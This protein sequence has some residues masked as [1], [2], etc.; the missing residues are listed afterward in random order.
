MRPGRRLLLQS[1]GVAL[2]AGLFFG[3][4]SFHPR[5]DLFVR[6]HSTLLYLGQAFVHFTDEPLVVVHQAIYRLT[7]KRL[8]VAALLGGEI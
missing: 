7:R 6:E 1:S 8:S 2:R 3:Q 5:P 4:Q